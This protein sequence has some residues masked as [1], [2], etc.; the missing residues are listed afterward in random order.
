MTGQGPRRSCSN[1]SSQPFCTPVRTHP[2]STPIVKPKSR[3]ESRSKADSL[4]LRRVATQNKRLM[5]PAR[6]FS[7]LYTSPRPQHHSPQQPQQEP[8]ERGGA[9]TD[10]GGAVTDRGGAQRE[11]EVR[12]VDRPQRAAGLGLPDESNYN[13]MVSFMEDLKQSIDVPRMRPCIVR[14]KPAI[15]GAVQ[16]VLTTTTSKTYEKSVSMKTLRRVVLD[17]NV[18]T[19]NP[20]SDRRSGTPGEVPPTVLFTRPSA[21][22]TSSSPHRERLN[23]TYDHHGTEALRPA[24]HYSTDNPLYF[25]GGTREDPNIPT[26][27]AF[28]L[29]IR[30]QAAEQ[31]STVDS[32]PRHPHND[33]Y[34]AARTPT[35]NRAQVKRPT[36]PS[37]RKNADFQKFHLARKLYPKPGGDESGPQIINSARQEKGLLPGTIQEEEDEERVSPA[38]RFAEADVLP[39]AKHNNKKDEI[40]KRRDEL[41]ES[42]RR[43]KGKEESPNVSGSRL[44][45]PK[46]KD[47][48]HIQ[49]GESLTLF[50]AL[51]VQALLRPL[52]LTVCSALYSDALSISIHCP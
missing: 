49:K 43:E 35:G 2:D 6:N 30:R 12:T 46:L 37:A 15:P 47:D 14:A 13:R 8:T 25:A 1:E 40:E 26:E 19:K 9:V 48:F 17:R 50:P 44:D 20:G 31:L 45:W 28:T 27:D 24:A 39:S 3:V 34:L 7:S 5:E 42:A 10:R 36:K 41:E 33:K 51:R 4:T 22:S 11:L 16:N 29:E 52:K 21:F 38:V 18:R 32:R 23:T